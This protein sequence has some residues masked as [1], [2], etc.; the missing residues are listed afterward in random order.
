MSKEYQKYKFMY[1]ILSSSGTGEKLVES[2]IECLKYIGYDTVINYDKEKENED[3]EEDLHI[4]Y[5]MA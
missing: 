2:I 4:Y 3:N 1:D 5:S